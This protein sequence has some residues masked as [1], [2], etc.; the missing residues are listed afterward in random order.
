L[1]EAVQAFSDGLFGIRGVGF[2]R[3]CLN[4]FSN[5]VLFNALFEILREPGEAFT[6]ES[7]YCVDGIEVFLNFIVRFRLWDGIGVRSRLR[8]RS[9]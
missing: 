9:R 7:A 1:C 8:S 6:E 5:G 2:H 3:A 4:L